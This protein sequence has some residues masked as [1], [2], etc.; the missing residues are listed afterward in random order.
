MLSE[1]GQVGAEGLGPTGAADLV[2]FASGSIE[3]LLVPAVQEHGGT[4]SGESV[5]K[6]LA[7]RLR[8]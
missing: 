7:R 3:L 6:G 5:R 1:V 4:I 2:Q 8:R